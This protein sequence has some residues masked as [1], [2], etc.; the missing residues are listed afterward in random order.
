MFVRHLLVAT[1]FSDRSRAALNYA[2]DLARALAAEIDL[3]HV[4]PPPPKTEMVIDAYLGRAL[5]AVSEELISTA[6]RRLESLLANLPHEGVRVR[7]LVEAGDPAATIVR[8]ASEL[9]SDLVLI[10]THARIGLSELV[11]GSVAHRVLT[12]APCPV[13]TLRGDEAALRPRPA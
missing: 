8:I 5:P 1:D 9:P 11:L 7:T 6:Q 4:V 2:V 10:G 12:C 13:V 3:L